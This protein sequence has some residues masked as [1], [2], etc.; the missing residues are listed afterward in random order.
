MMT[1]G[2]EQ[3]EPMDDDLQDASV[4]DW[5]L[6]R[7]IWQLAPSYRRRMAAHFPFLDKA[8]LIDDARFYGAVLKRMQADP[9]YCMTLEKAFQTTGREKD[10]QRSF[11][12]RAWRWLRHRVDGLCFD[13]EKFEPPLATLPELERAVLVLWHFA[14]VGVDVTKEPEMSVPAETCS[15]EPGDWAAIVRSLGEALQGMTRPDPALAEDIARLAEQLVQASRAQAEAE[16]RRGA[17]AMAQR[18]QALAESLAGLEGQ[19]GFA[20]LTSAIAH[21]HAPEALD[22]AEAAAAPVLGA[23]QGLTEAEQAHAGAVAHEQTVRAD[24]ASSRAAVRLALDASDEAEQRLAEAR[25]ALQAALA[26]LAAALSDLARFDPPEASEHKAEDAQAEKVGSDDWDPTPAAEPDASELLQDPDDQ[27]DIRPG[28]AVPSVPDEALPVPPEPA[29]VAAP[30]FVPTEPD[31]PPLVE[32]VPLRAVAPESLPDQQEQ[33]VWTGRKTLE[34]LTA[35]YLDTDQVALAWH[36]ADLAEERGLRPPVPAIALKSLL[37]GTALAGPYDPSTQTLGEWLAAMMS[38]VEETEAEGPL[39][40]LRARTAALAALMRPALIARDTNAREHLGNLSLGDGLSEF[41]PVVALLRDLRHDI[42]P[43]LTDLVD[44]EGGEKQRRLPAAVDAIKAWLPGARAAQSMHAP[45]NIVLHGLL[46]RTGDL[47]LVFEAALADQ[48][49]VVEQNLGFLQALSTDRRAA[50]DLVAVAEREIGR[51][52]RDAIRSTALDWIC[53]KLREGADLLL[54]WRAAGLQD[55]ALD[56]RRRELLRRHCNELRKE[57][58][59]AQ[60]PASSDGGVDAAVQRLLDKVIAEMLAVIGG[61]RATPAGRLSEVLQA[62]LLRL[63]SICQP[64]A[65]EGP[66]FAAERQIQRAALMDALSRP[67]S[68]PSDDL[69]ALDAHLNDAAIL[70][71]RSLI[72]RME[73]QG[74]LT[75]SEAASRRQEV[76]N[77]LYTATEAAR[78]AMTTL[79]HALEPLQSI[80]LATSQE[81]QQWLD[82]FVTIERALASKDGITLPM[83][84]GERLAAVPADFPQLH[85]LLAEAHRLREAVQGRISAEQKGRLDEIIARLRQTGDQRLAAEAE[86]VSVTLAQRDP[87]TVEDILI[88]LQNGQS[89]SLAAEAQDDHFAAFY[90]RFVAAIGSEPDIA[91]IKGAIS[92]GTRAGPLDYG[93][94]ED[95]D[96]KRALE[97]VDTWRQ[98]VNAM[99]GGR[100]VATALLSFMERLGFTSVRIERETSLSSQ[101]RWMWMRTNAVVAQDWFLPPVFGSEAQGSYPVFLAHRNVEGAQLVSEMAKVGRD[102]PCILL[103][104]SRLSKARREAFSLAMRRAKQ[105]VLLIDETQVLFLTQG[106]NWMERLFGCAAPFGYLQPYTTNAGNIPVEMFFGREEEIAKIESTRT[107]GSLVYGGRQLGKSALLHH[108]RKRFHQPQLGR[109]AYYLNIVEFGGEVQPAAQIWTEIRRVLVAD[110]VL[111]KSLEG[112]EEIRAGLLDWLA[113]GGERRILVLI[114]E[115][116]MFLASE[117]RSRFPNLN[118]LKDLME[119]TGRRFK[120]V[121]AGLHNVRRMAKAPNSPLV[122]LADPICIGPLNTSVESSRQARRLVVQPMRA[123]GFDYEQ[124]ELV[125]ALLTRVNFYPSLVQVFLKALLEGLANQARPPGPG[126]RWIL[127]RELLFES[128]SASGINAQIRERFQWTLNLDPRYELIAKVLARHR[129]LSGDGDG[130][131]MTADALRREAELFWPKGQEKL[132]AVD[133]PAFL[134]E[135]VDLGVLIRLPQG[136]FGL[137]GA[138]I[139]QML[140][141]LEQ[142]DDEILKIA[143]KEPR[144]DYDPNHYHRRARPDQVDRRAPLPDSGMAMLFDSKRP[145]VRMVVAAPAVFG[146]DQAQILAD[147]A[148]GWNDKEGRLSAEVFRGSEDDLRRLVERGA[149]RRVLVLQAQTQ[150]AAR[151]L[152]WLATHDMVRNGRV[153]PVFVGGPDAIAR[154]LPKDLPEGL[155]FFRA[156]PWERG[157]LRAWLS[158]TSL[159]LLDTPEEREALLAVTGGAPT[160]LTRLRPALEALVA[161]GYQDGIAA[162]LSGLGSSIRFAADDVGLPER[163]VPLFCEAA[164]LVDSQGAQE[165]D[166]LEYFLDGGQAVDDNIAQM[167]A[168]SLFYRPEPGV[169]ALSALGVLLYRDSTRSPRAS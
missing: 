138:Q 32:H 168:L 39:K 5:Q 1:R 122:H 134:D 106:G 25:E 7:D 89:P 42:Q 146:G 98:V 76:D 144:V 60:R 38:A 142:L 4:L 54:D 87:L 139:A 34:E 64:F 51:P 45:S 40:S 37:G 105:T 31:L 19:D 104:S 151:W 155:M 67:E 23:L 81:I 82:R 26:D 162:Q 101:F 133:F 156:R 80:D 161:R 125:H 137:R 113:K 83:S 97:L 17:A 114:D 16:A 20:D 36:L 127:T 15:D 153:L 44:L 86:D 94:L 160:A 140:G 120:V 48:A 107:D 109:R 72:N 46:A 33:A 63:P 65:S 121:F 112:P 58:E 77:T 158:E 11:A 57:L 53:R 131:V 27:S 147:L 74:R 14:I 99:G 141:Q 167:E 93:A 69:K 88:R 166:V 118:P 52:K 18:R 30:A 123:A 132:S 164:E 8:G 35:T 96:R 66:A 75:A 2:S 92:A 62:P 73:R 9:D 163:L 47:G 117:A 154:V 95:H 84:G 79:R 90:P 148:D 124:V 157:M 143:E 55:T 12:H 59:R 149:G 21:L 85:Q 129:I 6:M 110:Q 13:D 159:T 56:D 28:S 150:Q 78:R 108:V 100:E 3:V 43:S 41:A 91:A 61:Q 119:E 169:L 22:K 102:Q 135:M 136:V 115:A 68:P 71:A 111:P 103:M 70:S 145:G 152:G 130:G 50:E 29:V 49:E 128:S 126:P 165:A 10:G 116:D 24:P